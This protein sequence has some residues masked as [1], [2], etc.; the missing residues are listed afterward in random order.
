VDNQEIYRRKAGQQNFTDQT[1]QFI[2]K[3]STTTIKFTSEGSQ[4]EAGWRLFNIW[5][6]QYNYIDVE[7]GE[8]VETCSAPKVFSAKGVVPYCGECSNPLLGR[9]DFVN[10][11]GMCQCP[12]GTFNNG[13]K[14]T[15]SPVA[16][17]AQFSSS[18]GCIL[19]EN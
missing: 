16:N 11:E 13:I 18:I 19:C 5:V 10:I 9:S 4:K 12:K 8:C 17:C 7:S 14:C 15:N 3:S 1:V 2:G 6:T